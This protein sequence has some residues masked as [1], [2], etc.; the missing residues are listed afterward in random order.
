MKSFACSL[1]ITLLILAPAFAVNDSLTS[2][3]ASL[4]HFANTLGF[5]VSLEQVENI[6]TQK[7]RED[8]GLD[9]LTFINAAKEIGLE[10]LEQNPNY[11]H[12]Q[13]FETPMIATCKAAFDDENPRIPGV[14][15]A[16]HFIV[17]EEVTEKWV[18]I[19]GVSQNS[20]HGAATVIPRNRFVELWTGQIFKPLYVLTPAA[21]ELLAHL[22]T[23]TAAYKAKLKSGV[24]EFSITL[25]QAIEEPLPAAAVTYVEDGHLYEETGYWHITYRF[26]G[27]RQFYDIKARHKMEFHGHSLKGWRETHHQYR[28]LHRIL[29]FWEKIGTEWKKHAPQKMSARFKPHFNPHWWSWPLWNLRLT[30]LFRFFKPIDI[31]Q[32]NLENSAHYLLTGHK[33]GPANSDI[34][35]WLDSQKDYRPTRVL[36]HDRSVVGT[37]PIETADGQSNPI[38]LETEYTLTRYTYHLEKFAPDIWFPKIVT[39]EVS[40]TTIDENQ[41]PLP[42]LRRAIM[43]VHRAV[44]NI[45]IAEKELGGPLDMAKPRN[46]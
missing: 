35:V 21:T 6:L 33:T 24:I 28:I 2:G 10:L 29:H 16:R 40:F 12:L 18:R 20:A 19:Y 45:P 22:K 11:V 17:L 26:D 9:S 36:L 13:L 14:T 46:K 15:P 4:H 39:R 44:F 5:E 41:K 27:T 1:L 30:T 43:R 37:A 42:T 32:V 38:P 7:V 31:Q 23:E 3:A 8:R 34:E 25:S